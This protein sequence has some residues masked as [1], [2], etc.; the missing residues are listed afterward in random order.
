MGAP[1]F[2]VTRTV[3]ECSANRPDIGR[4]FGKHHIDLCR[5]GDKTLLEACD[6]QHLEPQRLVAELRG[7]VRP[8]Y[9]ELG[10]DE[11]H[12]SITELCNHLEANHHL[13]LQR[14]LRILTDLVHKVVS[15]Y[16]AAR[17]ELGELQEVFRRFHS[18][19]DRHLLTEMMVLAPALRDLERDDTLPNLSSE[20]L[21]QLVGQMESDHAFVDEQLQHIRKLT[22]G[23][24]APPGACAT[25]EAMLD[26]FWELEGNLHQKIYEESEALFPKVLRHRAALLGK[27][28]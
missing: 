17:P 3:A 13:P 22:N 2:D 27:L 10:F 5:D 26:S 14:Q 20:Y 4:V 15:T 28:S 8:P 6:E 18:R 21:P 25:Y 7:A 19:L 11:E 16:H 24:R 1:D 9:C 12:A 23:Y